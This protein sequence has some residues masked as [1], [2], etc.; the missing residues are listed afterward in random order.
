VR[1]LR[2]A[3]RNECYTDD[4]VAGFLVDERLLEHGTVIQ[5]GTITIWPWRLNAVSREAR[6]LLD[7]V[8]DLSC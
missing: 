5:P 1:E 8:R 6:Q 3:D 7:D 2:E 4:G